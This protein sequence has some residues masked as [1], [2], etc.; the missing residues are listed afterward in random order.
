M[1]G[2]K[3]LQI[4]SSIQTCSFILCLYFFYIL[5]DSELNMDFMGILGSEAMDAPGAVWVS[6]VKS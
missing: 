2:R 3:A 4:F 5:D 1:I 6:Q